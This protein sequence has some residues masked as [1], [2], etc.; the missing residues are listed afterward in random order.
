VHPLY[1][2]GNDDTFRPT[3]A[4]CRDSPSGPLSSTLAWLAINPCWCRLATF[5]SRSRKGRWCKG[6]TSGH[7]MKVLSVH[8][9]CD[10]D[11]LV[12]LSDPI[13]PACHTARPPD[14]SSRCQLAL[15]L[16]IEAWLVCVH[17]FLPDT[18]PPVLC[19]SLPV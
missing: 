11:S 12:Y 15:R 18:A 10:R 19:C 4:I 1:Y 17:L 16:C 8:P 13:G 2:G 5:Y 3:T 7:Y 6:E 14:C 9:D